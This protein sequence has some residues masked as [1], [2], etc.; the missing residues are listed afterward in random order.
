MHV[1]TPKWREYRLIEESS[2]FQEARISH[3]EPQF[4]FPCFPPPV[5]L[6]YDA[7]TFDF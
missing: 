3:A 5:V 1:Y 2:T 4:G 6:R 7:I